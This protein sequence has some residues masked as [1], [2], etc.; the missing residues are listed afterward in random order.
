MD[1]VDSG[2]MSDVISGVVDKSSSAG[3]G[4]AGTGGRADVCTR[5]GVDFWGQ[6]GGGVVCVAVVLG[7]I[8]SGGRNAEET[9]GW[10][11][12][13]AGGATPPRF[14]GRGQQKHLLVRA[15][16]L[17]EPVHYLSVV[18]RSGNLSEL[19]NNVFA[20]L[21]TTAGPTWGCEG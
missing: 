20:G 18:N 9:S 15:G 11:G 3:R 19:G 1:V 17:A 13:D 10:E 6:S 5:S 8:D 2:P 12:G 16:R 4:S 7:F 21:A 14:T